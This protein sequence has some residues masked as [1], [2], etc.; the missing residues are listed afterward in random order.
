MGKYIT[1]GEAAVG[2]DKT[3]INLFNSPA[4]PTSRGRIYDLLVGCGATPADQAGEFVVGRT[5]AVGTENSGFVPNALDPGDPTGEYDS[6]IAHSAEPTYTANKE[7][8]L[9][10]LNQRAT[11]RWVANPG[12]ELVLPATQNNGAGF[13]SRSNTGTATHQACIWFE[14]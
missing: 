3:I 2:T 4:T 14:E 13:K 1:H 9:M 8:L 11:G 7:L 12:C 5:T 10:G 6:G